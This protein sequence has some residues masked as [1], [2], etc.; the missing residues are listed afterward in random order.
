MPRRVGRRISGLPRRRRGGEA[1]LLAVESGGGAGA[2]LGIRGPGGRSW[3]P[4]PN[5]LDAA[6]CVV[7][8]SELGPDFLERLR[9]PRWVSSTEH[10]SCIS[11][12]SVLFLKTFFL[13]RPCLTFSFLLFVFSVSLLRGVGVVRGEIKTGTG[14]SPSWRFLGALTCGR[15]LE[16]SSGEGGGPERRFLL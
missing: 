5:P 4:G 16:P 3:G 1:R 6:V 2:A 9:L 13:S 15:G 11:P 7:C 8:T 12:N 10:C 14:S